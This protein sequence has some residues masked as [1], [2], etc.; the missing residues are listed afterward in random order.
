MKTCDNP[1]YENRYKKFFTGPKRLTQHLYN[2]LRSTK[3]TSDKFKQ[4][5]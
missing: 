4:N 3:E 2:D 5:R 1:D